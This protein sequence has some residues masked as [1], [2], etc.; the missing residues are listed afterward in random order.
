MSN[1]KIKCGIVYVV[2]HPGL[3]AVKVGFSSTGSNRLDGLMGKGWEPYRRL[4]VSNPA[5]ARRIE[6]AVLFEMRHRHYIPEYLTG[7]RM[8][9]SGWTETAVAS[10]VSPQR[11]WD[12]VCEQA[13]AE[14]LAPRVQRIKVY[15]PHFTV[16]GVRSQGDTPR[17]APVARREAAR[18]ARAAQV[19]GVV[20]P[21]KQRP[22]KNS[23]PNREDV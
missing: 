23:K 21:P 1:N 9:L 5:L 10:L 15:R 11:L 8:N 3:K 17:Y 4:Y 19:G 12:L 2:S 22:A 14:Q 13:G 7:D 20:Q 18:T 16:R 6:Q